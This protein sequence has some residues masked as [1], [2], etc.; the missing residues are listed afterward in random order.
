MKL[1]LSWRISKYYIFVCVWVWVGGGARAQACAGVRVA[2]LIQHA[3]RCRIVISGFSG[4]LM[5]FDIVTNGKIFGRKRGLLKEMFRF[6]V[7]IFSENFF[8]SKKN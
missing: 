6:S 8:H 3:T 5:L 2:L 1:L 7:G 4:F